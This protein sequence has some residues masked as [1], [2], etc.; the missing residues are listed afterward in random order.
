M[1][2]DTGAAALSVDDEEAAAAS[3]SIAALDD[4]L[5]EPDAE[6]PE[7][8]ATAPEAISAAESVAEVAASEEGADAAAAAAAAARFRRVLGAEAEAA[9]ATELTLSD[10]IIT[11]SGV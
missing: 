5:V 3:V 2:G 7:S 10:A 6:R 11:T 9:A 8:E 4:L 1:R